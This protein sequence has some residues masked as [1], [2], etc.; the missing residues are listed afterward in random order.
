MPRFDVKVELHD[1][2]DLS[3]MPTGKYLPIEAEDEDEA[4]FKMRDL[5]NA[6][7]KANAKATG[8][9][10]G[11]AKLV[12]R[13]GKKKYIGRVLRGWTKERGRRS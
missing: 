8:T 6:E 11:V 10:E 12:T 1:Y 4:V 3:D 9:R 2:A 7:R 13:T 5:L